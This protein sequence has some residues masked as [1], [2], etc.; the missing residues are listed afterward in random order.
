[1]Q[2]KL[3][4][5]RIELEEI[6]AAASAVL[7]G[8]SCAVVLD[9]ESSGGPRLV[10]FLEA[11]ADDADFDEKALH[12]ELSGR[13][14]G[15]LVP[16]RWARLDV[17]PTLAGGKPDRTALSR[18]AAALDADPAA[19]PG[20]GTEGA[21]CARADADPEPAAT[22]G[23]DD[24][25]TALLTEGWRTVLGHS[26]FDA[27]SHFFH[28][29]GHSLLAAELAAWLEP[30]LGTRPPLRIL[31]RNPVLADQADALATTAPSTES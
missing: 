3:R 7:G 6:E 19:G 5:H 12:A 14:P 16:A 25:M 21:P 1:N 2:I 20:T 13:L 27:R 24:P 11:G 15:P 22:T 23:S 29:G 28:S 30:R 31:F 18:R 4:G 26:R 10:G 17:M 9:R 8:R